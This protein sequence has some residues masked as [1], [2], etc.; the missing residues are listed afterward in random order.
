SIP[1]AVESYY[2]EVGRAGRDGAP[3]GGVLIYDSGDLRYAFLK[4]TASCPTPEAVARCFH[5]LTAE[6][7]APRDFDGW[8]ARLEPEVGPAARAAL[9]ALE[10]AGDVAVTGAGVERFVE[11]PTLH[12]ELLEAR[13][14]RERVRL[15]AMVGYVTRADCRMRY[16]VDYFGAAADEASPASARCGRCD[17]CAAPE[18]RALEG[19]PRRHAL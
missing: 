14:R 9:I 8:V 19:E 15:D 12:P 13:A 17:R 4:H 16:L 2:Q 10:Q 3:A 7:A 11:Q 5:V 1:S 6:A 18:G